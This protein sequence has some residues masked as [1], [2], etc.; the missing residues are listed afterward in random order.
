MAATNS[1]IHP[2]R[3]RRV[4]DDDCLGIRPL[5]SA[6]MSPIMFQRGDTFLVMTD[7]QGVD[8]LCFHA[9]GCFLA[10]ESWL[11]SKSVPVPEDDR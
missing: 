11:A 10:G 8:A 4:D 9:E 5:C 6:K 2:G 7:H 1:A 3:L